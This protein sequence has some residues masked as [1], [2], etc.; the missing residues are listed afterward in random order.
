MAEEDSDNNSSASA[1]SL[2][3][4]NALNLYW[5]VPRA[6]PWTSDDSTTCTDESS[7][8]DQLMATAEEQGWEMHWEDFS[9]VVASEVYTDL[10]PE[11]QGHE[12]LPAW[13]VLKGDL[14]WPSGTGYFR[15]P[16]GHVPPHGGTY[17][18]ASSWEPMLPEA[19][20]PQPFH[21]KAPE[22]TSPSLPQ[23]PQTSISGASAPATGTPSM[24]QPPPIFPSNCLP[25]Y[26]CRIPALFL[27]F[28]PIKSGPPKA[29]SNASPIHR[30]PVEPVPYVTVMN[31]SKHLPVH[32]HNAAKHAMEVP[33]KK[34]P[35]PP[36]VPA[37]NPPP[38][39]PTRRT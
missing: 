7:Y 5:E 21:S 30:H 20:L 23:L 37:K 19:C 15:I 29:P 2:V 28:P 10:V 35:P 12:E 36:P 1:E 38:H 4:C 25:N 9:D 13:M 22:P 31:Q 17:L 6:F 39:F 27:S 34:P 16:E 32:V 8:M 3:S 14:W 26:V 33:K 24:K 11:A 18:P